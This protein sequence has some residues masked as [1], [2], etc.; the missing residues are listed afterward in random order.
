MN[1][2]C[3]IEDKSVTISFVRDVISADGICIGKRGERRT[4]LPLFV[5]SCM[6]HGEYRV[7]PV[8]LRAESLEN[9]EYLCIMVYDKEEKYKR[10][11]VEISYRE[12]HPGSEKK[13]CIP[14]RNCG[15]C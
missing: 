1:E 4:F 12:Y 3:E 5:E 11:D 10:R 6:H 14:C 15:R 8:R 7:Y 13:G 9:E 2:I